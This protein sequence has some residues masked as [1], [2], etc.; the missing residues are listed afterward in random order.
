[1]TSLNDCPKGRSQFVTI[2]SDDLIVIDRKTFKQVYTLIGKC[3][4]Q[5]GCSRHCEIFLTSLNNY[6]SELDSPEASKSLLLLNTWLDVMPEEFGEIAGWL[7]DA[8]GVMKLIL[9]GS[10]MGE[11]HD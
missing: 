9:D 5:M 11:N 4:D 10:K 1:M 8:R 6:L 2:A 7:D 3:A